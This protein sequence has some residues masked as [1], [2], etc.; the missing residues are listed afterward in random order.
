MAASL[1]GILLCLE[2]FYSRSDI[3]IDAFSEP[4]TT[5]PRI[6]VPLVAIEDTF[7]KFTHIKTTIL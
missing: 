6:V 7:V 1:R 2:I 5:C 3:G 4:D